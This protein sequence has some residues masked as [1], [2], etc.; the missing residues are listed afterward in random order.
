MVAKRALF[1]DD[2]IVKLVERGIERIRMRWIVVG[3]H[4]HPLP[5][6]NET[7]EIADDGLHSTIIENDRRALVA[8]QRSFPLRA[9]S[10][11][12]I[13]RHV[14][15]LWLADANRRADRLK[16]LVPRP[17]SVARDMKCLTK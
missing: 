9:I 12:S 6:T 5:R 2:A 1:G 7:I 14:Y 17:L 11:E 15:E 3:D 4:S 16:D 10:N 13:A 8:K